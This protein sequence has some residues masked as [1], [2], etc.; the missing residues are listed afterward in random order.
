[1]V[2]VGASGSGK[3]NLMIRLWAGWYRRLAQRPGAGK[4]RPLLVALDCKG[5]PDAR[6]EGRPGHRPQGVP[7]HVHH[8]ALHHGGRER[9]R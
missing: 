9:D 8:A 1:M 3:T 4:P 2:I 7:D 5:G 6:V